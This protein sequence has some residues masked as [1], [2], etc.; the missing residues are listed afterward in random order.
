MKKL[1]KALIFCLA[2][3]LCLPLVACNGDE[4]YYAPDTEDG[5]TTSP[6]TKPSKPV[7]DGRFHVISNHT[8]LATVVYSERASADEIRLAQDVAQT[9]HE[10]TGIT[11]KVSSD[12]VAKIEDV[13]T[14]APE[15][16]IG[17]TNR[18][19]SVSLNAELSRLTFAIECTEKK[20]SIVGSS[21]GALA[22][23][24]EYFSSSFIE[25]ESVNVARGELSVVCG[26]KYVSEE[27]PDVPKNLVSPGTVL[28]SS[29]SAFSEIAP[30]GEMSVIGGTCT[31]GE[32]LYA[33]MRQ[34]SID[35]STMSYKSVVVKYSLSPFKLVSVSNEFDLG[36]G[37][38]MDYDRFSDRLVILHSSVQGK[39]KVSFMTTGLLNVTQTVTVSTRLSAL[40]A[41]KSGGFTAVS[42][43]GS[44]LL[45]LDSSL[46]VK[47]R[48]SLRMI[49]GDVS[50]VTTDGLFVYVLTNAKTM[51]NVYTSDGSY[52]TRIQI[53]TPLE[54]KS[55]YVA[56]DRLYVGFCDALWSKG[57]LYELK[58]S[59]NKE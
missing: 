13:N 15:I 30:V 40:C 1:T 48:T 28:K 21:L 18:P 44:E 46:S 54:A 11:L 32:H 3:S 7:S 23:G 39:E 25:S 5:T 51:L 27:I 6:D 58:L 16:L 45:T 55:I 47:S 31:D 12:Y 49:G 43:D 24:V 34:G 8:P 19:A 59:F 37:A 52:V 26:T 50:A 42:E 36:L 4:P 29:L 2:L 22:L 9:I 14:D 20:L 10:R 57:E 41:D 38:D 53:D 33:V 56:G 35:L 17:L